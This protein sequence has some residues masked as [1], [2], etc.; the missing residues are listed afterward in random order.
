MMAFLE[1]TFSSAWRFVGVL[2]LIIVAG[3]MLRQ[4]AAAAR[5]GHDD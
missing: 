3:E 2:L 1:F 5:G 4:V